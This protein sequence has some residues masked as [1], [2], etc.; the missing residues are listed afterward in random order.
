MPTRW[1]WA[2]ALAVA[3]FLHLAAIA[4]WQSRSAEGALDDGEQ[5]VE[6]GLGLLGDLGEADQD[7]APTPA[8]SP[9]PPEQAPPPEQVQPPPVQ[10]Q[11]PAQVTPPP[12]QAQVPPPEQVRPP[13]VQVRPQRPTPRRAVA[14]ETAPAET[15]ASPATP[16]RQRRGAG[17]ANV[18][19]A[20]A[21]PGAALSYAARLAAH[22]NRH[23]RY[24]LT[25]R[26]RREEG[27]V[28][29]Q[30]LIHRDGTLL[31]GHVSRPGPK[32]LS[33]AARRMLEEAKPLP[34]FP[35][36]MPQSRIDVVVPISFKLRE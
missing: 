8:V 36:G 23:K 5:G 25:A 13:P 20:G 10:V 26:R 32:T 30:L 14:S 21:S 3:T 31:S 18:D 29:L 34:P 35:D 33:E 1:H 6:I 19:A 7:V 22:L 4:A 16:P 27:V 17:R 15:Y 9:P 12:E 28:E 24:P 11:P 2:V